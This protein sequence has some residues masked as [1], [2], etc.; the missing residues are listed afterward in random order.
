M[1]DF[2]DCPVSLRRQRELARFVVV[3]DGPA[4]AA[5][6]SGKRDDL[7]GV[8]GFAKLERSLAYSAARSD[9]ELY[10][11]FQYSD[12]NGNWFDAADVSEDEAEHVNQAVK[13]LSAL[14]LLRRHPDQ[15]EFVQV[16]ALEVGSDEA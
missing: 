13:Y 16:L 1:T 10:C 12:V 14:G 15:M 5:L 6:F 2:R 7:L 9:I 4:K 11:Q 8:S 3:G